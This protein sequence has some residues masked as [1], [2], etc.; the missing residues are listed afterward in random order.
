MEAFGGTVEEQE[1]CTPHIHFILRLLNFNCIRGNISSEVP[2]TRERARKCIIEYY[3]RIVE[4]SYPDLEV[5]HT[6]SKESN[7]NI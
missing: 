4:S 2:E 3:S 6:K 1:R 7:E 5:N